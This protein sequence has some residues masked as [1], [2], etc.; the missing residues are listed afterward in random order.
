MVNLCP[1]CCPYG[2]TDKSVEELVPP[3]ITSTSACFKHLH[4][5]AFSLVFGT[6]SGVCIGTFI[7]QPDSR[8]NPVRLEK[9]AVT[10]VFVTNFSLS[11]FSSS[12]ISLT[13]T[14]Q[15]IMINVLCNVRY[16]QSLIS[17]TQG[18]RFLFIIYWCRL[19]SILKLIYWNNF[20]KKKNE[21]NEEKKNCD[22]YAN[23]HPRNL[24]VPTADVMTKNTN[25]QFKPNYLQSWMLETT[26]MR[27]TT[28]MYGA[29]LDTTQNE[30]KEEQ[31]DVLQWFG[32]P[33]F[34]FKF[35]IFSVINIEQLF[36][37]FVLLCPYPLYYCFCYCTCYPSF[38]TS[39]FHHSFPIYSFRNITFL[40]LYQ[41]VP[42]G[43]N[44]FI[45]ES[46]F[47]II[48][49][50]IK[51]V[52]YRTGHRLIKFHCRY[53]LYIPCLLHPCE[54]NMGSTKTCVKTSYQLKPPYSYFPIVS[55]LDSRNNI[56]LA[57]S[58]R[59]NQ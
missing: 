15:I 3:H 2:C 57:T 46:F 37:L 7:F 51:V 34:K 9:Q 31:Q 52:S 16:G 47:C 40:Y 58:T 26:W 17:Q 44:F 22:L 48:S 56:P 1:P 27:L 29:N 50:I 23:N 25:G 38:R 39:C 28:T 55:Y 33:H 13:M 14:N 18:I 35:F 5:K 19:I 42:L 30:E 32:S 21:K 49:L 41:L 36:P 53:N 59:T 43:P 45:P 4:C 24:M 11:S 8:H 20:Q 10:I 6:T 54:H 12:E